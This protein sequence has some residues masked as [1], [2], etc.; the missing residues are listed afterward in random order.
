MTHISK[1]YWRF[2]ACIAAWL[3]IIV[4][5][6]EDEQVKKNVVKL[7]QPLGSETEITIHSGANAIQTWLDYF[8]SAAEWLFY[9]A[10]GVCIIWILIGAYMIMTAGL[11]GGDQKA[12]EGWGRIRTAIIG[13]LL[14]LFS[15][16]ILRTLNSIFFT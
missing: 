5:A 6:Q 1:A 11:T 3:P 12:S 2:V 7:Q 14:L 10:V 15:G 16:F 13:V 8:E 4:A 9:V